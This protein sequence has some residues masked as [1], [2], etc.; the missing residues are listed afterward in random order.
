MPAAIPGPPPFATATVAGLLSAVAQ[1]IGGD[2]TF[3]GKVINTNPLGLQSYTTG[4]L[5][6]PAS[7][8]TGYLVYNSTT[9]KVMFSD[10]AAWVPLDVS[11]GSFVSKTGDTMTGALTITGAG[12]VV[13]SADN[14]LFVD[15]TGNLV[16]IG[17]ATPA[18]K[19]D[20]ATG[21]LAVRGATSASGAGAFISHAS[22]ITTISSVNWTGPAYRDLR[23]EAQ[24]ISLRTGTSSATERVLV[25]SNGNVAFDTN[26]L[27]VDAVNNRVGILSAT[28]S[29]PLEVAG[30][31]HSTTGGIKFPDNTT[32]TTVAV[33]RVGDTMTGALVITGAGLT[34]DSADSALVVNSTTNR[35]GI[36]T[37]SPARALDISQA[38][39][40][41]LMQ[42]Q[43]TDVSG[44]SGIAFLSNGGVERLRIGYGNPSF[45]A[46]GTS[47]NF[48]HTDGVTDT[49]IAHAGVEFHRFLSNG[50][51]KFDQ[52]DN[53]LV[54]DS[55][56]NRVGFGT[57]TPS[58]THLV[59]MNA[60]I[61]AN[62]KVLKL[63]NNSTAGFSAVEFFNSAGTSM[64]HIG[65]SN[66]AVTGSGVNEFQIDYAGSG[67]YLRNAGSQHHYFGA[68]GNVTFDTADNVFFLN[69]ANN[70][71]GIM[72]GTPSVGSIAGFTSPLTIEL[73]ST[74][75]RST[76]IRGAGTIRKGLSIHDTT[77]NRTWT[78]DHNTSSNNN[79]FELQYHNGT[80][81]ARILTLT[82]DGKLGV[83]NITPTVEL[84][85]VGSAQFSG[86]LTVDTN[87][88][89]V[90]A[91]GNRV[92]I[93]TT[94]A[95]GNALDVAGGDV[96]FTG[97]LKPGG[98]A[99][100]TGQV[101]RSNGAGVTPTWVD[102]GAATMAIGSSV[103]SG[104]VGSI[105]F[106]GTGPILAQNNA[107][108]FWDDTNNR[109]GIDNA[110]PSEAL[111][112]TGNVRFSGALM[113]NNLA[114]TSGQVL[115]S[116]GAGVVPTWTT[117]TT[118][119]VT[120]TG[121]SGSVAFWTASSVI[122]QDASNLFWDDTNNRLGIGNAAPS[123]A[124]QV[125]GNVRF[126][127]ALM[128][129][130]SAGTSGQYLQS[131][132][133][134]VAP[135]WVTPSVITGTGTSGRLTYWTGTST[136]GDDS[137]LL[138]DASNNL[139]T[140]S[141]AASINPALLIDK[142]LSTAFGNPHIWLGGNTH[143][144]SGA[145]YPIAFGYTAT[146]GTTYAP[147]EIGFI[148]TDTAGSSKGDLYF[149]TRDVT[150]GTTIPTERMRIK[151]SGD[152]TIDTNTLVVDA[153][154][155][156]V[157]IVTTSPSEALEVTGNV[158]FSGALMPG[159]TAGTSGQVLT[160][161][162]AGVVPTWSTV[163]GTDVT[164][165]AIGA[166]PNANGASLS[167]QALTLQ[168][169]SASF[170]GVVTTAAQSFAGIKTFTNSIVNSEILGL[171]KIATG[172]LPAAG[173]GNEGYIV[174]DDT[175]NTVKFS[176][177]ATWANISS[178]GGGD[179]DEETQVFSKVYSSD[180]V[181]TGSTYT[182]LYSVTFNQLVA[183]AI[184]VVG[185]E[186][187]TYLSG[188]AASGGSL[189][190]YYDGNLIETR[191]IF[192][193]PTSQHFFFGHTIKFTGA[194]STGNKT[195]E[196]QWARTSGSGEFNWNADDYLN[197]V[198][199]HRAP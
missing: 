120:G 183:N 132:G 170:G 167:V 24:A 76:L 74:G 54:V 91:A 56:N 145:V 149:A 52:A 62:G 190:L 192:I 29:S 96:A 143:N 5:P 13:D 31:I 172:S 117:P 83:N 46:P 45:A 59:D 23:L 104:A 41:Y 164:L 156:R 151:A 77:N 49:V 85:V 141:K 125:A 134:G 27:V 2:K 25:S 139:L 136:I 34:V 105:L 43:N 103:T 147:G 47:L 67:L 188:S 121:T 113:P 58:A 148:T 182:V 186:L 61:A 173:A 38:V 135:T 10:G 65:Y 165:T 11:S 28:P 187:L 142:D 95:S 198:V 36:G 21:G 152:V 155:N 70:L 1:S 94:P 42:I 69:S 81:E 4:T 35:V 144:T 48:W 159:G 193:N 44:A 146:P 189:R 184:M 127:G 111:H 177:G 112:V 129:N 86:G 66:G 79:R 37:A 161:A 157:G 92:G 138:W 15:A 140:I 154:N 185:I 199:N 80:S 128:P 63:R 171:A 75:T 162:G 68:S 100:T 9:S 8:Y 174:Y 168:P 124:L 87:T 51:I 14:T 118:G 97:A 16:G 116:A 119:T 181:T 158:R 115:T 22:S 3:Y 109:L 84:D 98:L 90:D 18:D 108:L 93:G 191:K 7:A 194:A 178:G 12:L 150:T 133:A 39:A 122:G 179:S 101:L 175:T 73:G 163:S 166:T 82:T 107:N 130:N 195:L 114:G 32:Q 55:A 57:A 153:T 180:L 126:S 30:V 176:D 197:L 99:G 17:T 110:A 123:E 71:V 19:L 160:S 40:D 72:T 137:N 78:W 60:T 169:A 20:V 196:I 102:A 50:T 6:S 106:V 131:A 89:V 88:L 33:A 26:T 64:G 53:L